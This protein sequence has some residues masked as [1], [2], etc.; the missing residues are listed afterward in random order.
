MHMEKKRTFQD[1]RPETTASKAVP[2]K[3]PATS[4]GQS[5]TGTKL[6]EL[7]QMVTRP[8]GAS[9]NDLVEATGW[10]KH[11]IRAAIT[12]AVQA[13]IITGLASTRDV[14]GCRRYSASLAAPRQSEEEARNG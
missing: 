8:S 2:N 5:R 11:S 9:M 6:S 4:R 14:D 3:E 1:G 12:K 13:K 7:L 10:Q